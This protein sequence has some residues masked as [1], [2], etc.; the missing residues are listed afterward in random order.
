MKSVR[1]PTISWSHW[2]VKI[3]LVSVLAP[4]VRL[5][6]TDLVVSIGSMFA[7]GVR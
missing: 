4:T 5:M 2:A 3:R 6:G 1:M 7:G